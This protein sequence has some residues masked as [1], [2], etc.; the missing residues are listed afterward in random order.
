[1]RVFDSF[2]CTSDSDAEMAFVTFCPES[3]VSPAGAIFPLRLERSSLSATG[4]YV[5]FQGLDDVLGFNLYSG[6]LGQWFDHGAGAANVCD[7]PHEDLGSG[8]LRAEIELPAGDAY[9]LITAFDA[10]AEGPSH[11]ASSGAPAD[12]AQSTCAP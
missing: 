5:H 3:E 12:P 7:L 9:F 6:T 2:G 10:A 4:A 8:A 11:V 1:V